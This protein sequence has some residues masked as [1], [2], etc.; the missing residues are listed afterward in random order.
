MRTLHRF[1]DT[2]VKLWL[3]VTTVLLFGLVLHETIIDHWGAVAAA[4]RE[5]ALSRQPSGV[6]RDFRIAVV[7]CLLAGYLAA[8]LFAVVRGGRR[9][10]FELQSALDCTD[11]ECAALAGSIRFSRGWLLAA[12]LI[13]LAFAFVTPYLVP[14]VPDNLWHPSSWSPEVTWHRILGPIT[15]VLS[16]VL[17]YAILSVSGR[18]SRLASR[19]GSIDLFDHRPLM[20][21]T[22]QGLRNA[23]L[24]IGLFSIYGLMLLTETGFGLV[25]LIIGLATLTGAALTLVLSLRG[26]HRRIEQAK[27]AELA[28]LDGE[29]AKRRPS[30][31]RPLEGAPGEFADL[32]AYRREVKEVA[33]WPVNTS[34]WV[35]FALYSLIPVA[36]WAAAAVVERFVDALL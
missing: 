11:E 2:P 4:A 33:E 14:P 8:A 9:T 10:V 32:A 13:G 15:S 31:R 23:L 19:L 34:T 3:T 16:M 5:G 28:W 30:R 22:H 35:R 26:V 27:N 12:S 18:M 1:V 6:L 17:A 29:L 36:S 24:L 21:F 20:P 25:A 7:H